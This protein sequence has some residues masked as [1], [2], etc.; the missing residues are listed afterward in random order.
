MSVRNRLSLLFAVL[1]GSIVTVFSLALYLWIERRFD[2]ELHQDLGTRSRMFAR[3]FAD[4]YEEVK[5]GVH[6]DLGEEFAAHLS[7]SADA[8]SVLRPD[9]TAVYSTAGFPIV[10]E[11]TDFRREFSGRRYRGTLLDIRTG[12]GMTFR[13]RYAISEEVIVQRLHQLRIYFVFF[14]PLTL[15][16]G[17]LAGT[18]FVG[19]ALS[20]VEE[21][22]LQAER[23][24][25]ENLSERIPV[26]RA[27]GEFSNLARTLNEMLDR[28]DRAFQDLQ[29]FAADAAH[30]LRTPLA[31][32]RAELET[33]LSGLHT[34]EGYDRILTSSLEEVE[35]MCRVVADLFTLTKLDLKQYALQRERVELSALLREVRETWQPASQAKGIEIV[36]DGEFQTVAGDPVALRRVFMNLAENAIKY[37][38]DGGKVLLLLS[39]ESGH[40]RVRVEDTGLGIPAEHLPKLFRRFYRIDPARSREQG[41]AGLGLALCKSFVEAHQGTIRVQSTPGKG[42]VF[43]VDLPPADETAPHPL[44]V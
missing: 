4:K 22:R 20:P 26:P 19:R 18:F 37:N 9:G 38:R 30:E 23:I 41:G 5:R 16:L 12:D 42:T 14:C 13:L 28:L 35:R 10:A 25:R 39:R 8:V 15:I 27:A 33:S 36:C 2:A 1:T 29:N 7:S 17:W 11:G 31:N 3:Y 32:L 21:M 24:S 34:A 44:P 40:I 6:P 43:T